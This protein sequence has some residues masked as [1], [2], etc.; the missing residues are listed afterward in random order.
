MIV[1]APRV[2][3]PPFGM[4]VGAAHC[5]STGAPLLLE[6]AALELLPPEPL[7]PELL[8]PEAPLDPEPLELPL[9]RDADPP[10]LLDAEL[11]SAPELPPVPPPSLAPP[12]STFGLS[13]ES[14]T[15]PQ[16]AATGGERS[17]RR[18][19]TCRIGQSAPLSQLATSVHGATA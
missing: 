13:S 1:T 11:P 18:R 3:R 2:T 14:R 19:R 16:A 7:D 10:E 17:A 12:S 4:N 5:G 6:L 8:A 9:L 15:R